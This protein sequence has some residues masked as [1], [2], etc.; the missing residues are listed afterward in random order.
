MLQTWGHMGNDSKSGSSLIKKRK[1]G[2]CGSIDP[3]TLWLEDMKVL[4]HSMQ[5]KGCKIILC[6]DFNEDLTDSKSKI[7][8]LTDQLGLREVLLEK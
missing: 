4:I 5:E 1:Q 7:R 2:D 3:T 8:L 6:G